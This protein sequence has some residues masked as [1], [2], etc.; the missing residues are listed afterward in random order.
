MIEVQLL[1]QPKRVSLIRK[2]LKMNFKYISEK[3]EFGISEKQQTGNPRYL[4][5]LLEVIIILPF[6]YYY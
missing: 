1:D 5:T 4:K 2:T 6:C 3:Q